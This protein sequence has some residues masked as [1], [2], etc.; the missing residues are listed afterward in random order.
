MRADQLTSAERDALENP[1]AQG[2]TDQSRRVA[3][4][5]LA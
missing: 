1:L 3:D 4:F 2:A 5:L